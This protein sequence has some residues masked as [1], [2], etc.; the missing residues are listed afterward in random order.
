MNASRKHISIGLI[1]I[2]LLMNVPAFSQNDVRA[3]RRPDERTMKAKPETIPPTKRKT[4]ADEA[5]E[6]VPKAIGGKSRPETELTN[7]KFPW[8]LVVGIVIAGGIAAALLLRKKKEAPRATWGEL[9][10]ESQPTGAGIYLDGRDTYRK[11]DTTFTDVEEGSH[12]IR[13]VQVGYEDITQSVTVTAG[14]TSRVAA[15]FTTPK[16]IEFEMIRIPGG[17]FAMGAA[18]VYA[19]ADEKP[20]H[21]VTVSSFYLGKYEVTQA[22]WVSVMQGANPSKYPG[23]TN[24][25]EQVSWADAQLFIEKLNLMT[26]QRYRLPTEAEWEYAGRA[27]TTGSYYGGVLADIAWYGTSKTHPV[28]EKRPNAFGLY[29]MLGNVRE[30]CADW[31][32]PYTAE[33]AVNPKGPSSGTIRII[34]GGSFTDGAPACRVSER[35]PPNYYGTFTNGF[36]L[37]KD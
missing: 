25:V 18:D 7:K 19:D 37:A 23:E 13:L 28:G 26:G 5:K 35:N 27:G 34:R 11:T 8:R 10:I 3:A 9:R 2:F 4:A 12:T 30:W 1:G 14:K 17:T 31:Y 22:L 36:R 16:K 24:P 33:A 6:F 32:G 20:V 15:N 21:Q 29:D